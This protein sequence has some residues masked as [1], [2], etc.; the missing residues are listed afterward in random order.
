MKL[1][2]GA[3]LLVVLFAVAMTIFKFVLFKL[4]VLFFWVAMIGL[5]IYLISNL[6]KKA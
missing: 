6:L 3:F 1:L 2:L 4:F 5:A